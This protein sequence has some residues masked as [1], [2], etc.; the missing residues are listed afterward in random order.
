MRRDFIMT[1]PENLISMKIGKLPDN[2]FRKAER[3]IIKYLAIKE[4]E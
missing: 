1:I 3:R 4:H 2:I